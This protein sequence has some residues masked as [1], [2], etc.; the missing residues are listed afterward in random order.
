MMK[1]LEENVNP[2]LDD[3]E[4]T[5]FP[6]NF[7]NLVLIFSALTVA[8]IAA[9]MVLLLFIFSRFEAIAWH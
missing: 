3:I 4:F 8:L 1:Q 7:V 6:V 2:T 9:F 5:R